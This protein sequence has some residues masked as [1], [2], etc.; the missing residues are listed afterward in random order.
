ANPIFHWGGTNIVARE[1][2]PGLTLETISN[3][4]HGITHFFGVPSIYLFMSQHEDF[5]KTDLSHIDSWGC[6]GASLPVSLLETYAKR[7]IIIQLG[8][9]MTET[10]PTVF[11][12]ARRH[13]LNKPTSVGKPLLHTDV[14]V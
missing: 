4:E 8:F 9:G 13:V 2:D 6:G 5:E 10:S 3:R 1:F 11:L 12:I 14:R 7:G